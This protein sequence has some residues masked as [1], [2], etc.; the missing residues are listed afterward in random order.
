MNFKR[1]KAGFMLTVMMVLTATASIAS[2]QDRDKGWF[3]D[4]TTTKPLL[5]R[6]ER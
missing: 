6:G 2:G 4:T 5:E 1:R 3:N